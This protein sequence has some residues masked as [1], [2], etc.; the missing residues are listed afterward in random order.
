MYLMEYKLYPCAD[1]GTFIKS[2]TY[3]TEGV[4]NGY[5]KENYYFRGFQKGSN[6]FQ[7][8]SPIAYFYRNI[9]I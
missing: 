5:F 4:G 1:R 6:I 3:I 9:Y 8:G 2:S 7:G